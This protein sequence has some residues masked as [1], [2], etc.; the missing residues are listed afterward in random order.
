M[1][2]KLKTY[3]PKEEKPFS[4]V[5]GLIQNSKHLICNRK[6]LQI[7]SLAFFFF[8]L[9]FQVFLNLISVWWSRYDYSH[10]VLIPFISAYL[11][12]INR[13]RL[14]LLRVDPRPVL[15]FSLV[16]AAGIL[17]FMGDAGSI[18]VL[19]GVSI[20]VMIFG[21]VV[22]LS[23]FSYLKILSLPIS[24]LFLMTPVLD[25]LTAALSWPFQL[26]TAKMAVFMLQ[27]IGFTVLLD[28]QYIV[29]PQITLEVAKVCSGTGTLIALVTISLPMTYIFLRTW[30]S[31]ISLVFLA[32][33]FSIAA[34]WLRVFLIAVLT[35]FDTE[36]IHGPFHILQG[37]FSTWVG[38]GALFLAAWLLY[39]LENKYSKNH[40]VISGQT[41]SQEP[42]KEVHPEKWKR[43]WGLSMALTIGLIVFMA[44]Y[45]RGPVQMK[46]DF[47]KFPV[48]LGT[49]VS[50]EA[51][52][53][54][55]IFRVEGADQ[56]TF[57]IY[58]DR[59]NHKIFL[60]MAYLD[61]QRQGKEIVNYQTA[62]LHQD[63]SEMTVYLGKNDAIMINHGRYEK[64][65]KVH[66]IYFWYH[67]NEDVIADPIQAKLILIQNALINGHTNGAFFLIFG[68]DLEADD[69]QAEVDSLIQ[70]ILTVLPEYI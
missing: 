26:M 54:D 62:S 15:G 59:K 67:A 43:A 48:S 50:E 12:W 25:G 53:Q 69:L 32:V 7:A 10:G 70:E 1:D 3:S 46:K 17:L 16:L 23:G 11:I 31:R 18:M 37:I 34:N 6:N 60:Y 24:F 63:A 56:E 51:N 39:K 41:G 27:R 68:R 4:T 19:G 28:R 49:W 61:S 29:L 13:A 36:L 64:L 55:S 47:S 8:F 20:V 45:D 65:K 52:I 30:A 5:F 66:K 58:R 2:T 57:R 9:Y 40:L 33:F 14:A 42:P 35:R 21:L 22:I 44:R 38:Y